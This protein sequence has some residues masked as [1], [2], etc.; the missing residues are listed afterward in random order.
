MNYT[1]HKRRTGK[2]M[3]IESMSYPYAKREFHQGKSCKK[4]QTEMDFRAY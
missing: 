1:S 2:N 4:A 3:G